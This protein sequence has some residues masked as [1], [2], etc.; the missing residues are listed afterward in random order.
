MGLWSA[1][2]SAVVTRGQPCPSLLLLLLLLLVLVQL[3]LVV[4]S[5]W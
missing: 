1:T 4:D 2:G 3:L 5:R